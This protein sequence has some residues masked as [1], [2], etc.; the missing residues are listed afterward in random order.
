MPLRGP[1]RRHGSRPGRRAGGACGCGRR[2]RSTP[3]RRPDAPRADAVAPPRRRGR[4]RDDLLGAVAARPHAARPPR[5]HERLHHRVHPAVGVPDAVER[6]AGRRGR[7]RPPARG[8]GRRRC[9]ASGSSSPG[10]RAARR[11]SGWQKRASGRAAPSRSIVGRSRANGARP[12]EGAAARRPAPP[13]RGSAR[14]ASRKASRWPASAG[15]SARDGR[16][17]PRRRSSAKSSRTPSS[18]QSMR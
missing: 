1:R 17:Q 2:R 7:R 8:T 6:A 18:G 16:A 3:R 12:L 13:A 11:S 5:P 10:A 15:D 4:P 14:D 9:R